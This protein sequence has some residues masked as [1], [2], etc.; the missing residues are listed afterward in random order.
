[1]T[2]PLKKEQSDL[3]AVD[4]FLPPY[5]GAGLAGS[6]SLREERWEGEASVKTE[7]A[8]QM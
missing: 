7:R 8:G 6:D 5:L 2:L 3:Q 1:M 4:S